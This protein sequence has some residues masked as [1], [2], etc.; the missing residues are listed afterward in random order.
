MNSPLFSI[1]IPTYNRDNYI[2]ETLDSII[3]QTYSDWECIVVDDGSTDNTEKI[4]SQYV[5]ADSRIQYHKRPDNYGAGGNG[6]RNYGFTLSKGEFINWFDS[7]DVMLPDCLQK[8]IDLIKNTDFQ[9]VITGGYY[10]DGKKINNPLAIYPT[11][12]FYADLQTWK[13][14]L[15]T[16]C[17]LFRK[18]FLQNKELFSEQMYRSQET[19]F[20]SRIF[21]KISENVY[22]IS[23]EPT[24]LYRQHTNSITQ[25]ANVYNKK[26]LHSRLKLHL[27]NLSRSV[28]IKHKKLISY[29]YKGLVLQFFK[30]LD[31]KD[32]ENI[33]LVKNN[34]Y[35]KLKEIN[36][37]VAYL[38][39][40]IINLLM[41]VKMVDKLFRGMLY[42]LDVLIIKG[43]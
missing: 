9:F 19:E 20:F 8:K 27:D 15:T 35:N 24:F 2:S 28:E 43:L 1:I 17:V 23:S 38:F 5:T 10:W 7:D 22:I 12:D 18:S 34:G 4:V 25:N 14:N 36:V 11:N 29:H 40:I 30:A 6:A 31:N 13:L 41:K 3:S 32:N 26:F 21:F 42:R 16:N 39:I 37:L 33:A